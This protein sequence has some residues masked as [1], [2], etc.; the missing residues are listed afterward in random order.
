MGV[1]FFL[2]F[3]FNNQ[4][5]KGKKGTTGAPRKKP[6]NF[7]PSLRLHR[8]PQRN[9]RIPQLRDSSKAVLQVWVLLSRTQSSTAPLK[10]DPKWNPNLENYPIRVSGFSECQAGIAG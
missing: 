7:G 5:E 9:C 3:G 2:L 1:P 10:Q 8:R 4:K 6:F